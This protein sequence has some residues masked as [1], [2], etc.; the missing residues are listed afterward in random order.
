[1]PKVGI[2]ILNYNGRRFLGE[3][4]D[5]A[6]ESAINQSYGKVEVLFADN[7][8]TDDSVEYVTA[9][10][11]GRVKVVSL[12][13][14]YGFCLG[15]NL[16]VKHLPRDVRYILF[17][18]PDAILE[19]DYVAKLVSIMERDKRIAIAQ[20]LQR[21]LNGSFSSLGGFI[22][23][24]GRAVEVDVTGLEDKVMK[25]NIALPVLWASGSAMI[26][27]R[28]VFEA[29]GGFPS[30]FFMY[31]DEIDLCSRAILMGYKVVAY[32]GA[33]YYHKR[34]MA[35]TKGINWV[36]WYFANRNKWFTSIRYLPT[37]LLIFTLT[38]YLSFEIITNILKSLKR[39]NR[40]RAILIIRI[41]MHIMKN[42]KREL[43]IRKTWKDRLN[44][45]SKYIV[46]IK[47]PLISSNNLGRVGLVKAIKE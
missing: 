34:G 12:G 30:E 40:L 41:L 47:S 15:N 10:Y 14:N 5:R 45:L 19:R 27:R 6:I 4:L 11:S 22:D 29:L 2:V 21:S 20:G 13:E 32:P 3:L 23:S 28:E 46:K 43:S 9:K 33:V 1:M 25:L 38:L 7:G 8:S 35:E 37:K 36:S 31:H 16:A 42:L 17:M 26:V 39:S 44:S 24:Y 18:N